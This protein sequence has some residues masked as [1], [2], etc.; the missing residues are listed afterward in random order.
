[1]AAEDDPPPCPADR[2]RS[3]LVVSVLAALMTGGAVGYVIG[4]WAPA[5]PPPVAA[6]L[7][8][9][10]PPVPA[11]PAPCTDVAQRGTDLLASLDRAARAIAELDPAG[12][13]DVVDEIERLRDALR[14]DVQACRERSGPGPAGQVRPG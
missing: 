5:P 12:L 3:L 7:P 10:P 8:P 2:R 13:R 11:G 1:M 14:T 4:S 9:T 6:P